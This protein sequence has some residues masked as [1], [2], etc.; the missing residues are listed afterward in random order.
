VQALKD[1]RTITTVGAGI[2]WQ[3]TSDR[4]LNVG[5]DFAVSTDD[6]AAFIQIGERF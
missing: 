2:R 3:A 5:L 6:R 4:D 1:S